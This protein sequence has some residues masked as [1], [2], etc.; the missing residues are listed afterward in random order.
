LNNG[1]PFRFAQ[2]RDH[3]FFSN[4]LFFMTFISPAEAVLSSFFWSKNRQEDAPP[5]SP[6]SDQG[7]A[8]IQ[9]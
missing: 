7:H 2:H 9:K 3:L 8:P 1:N 4:R 5:Q 6:S